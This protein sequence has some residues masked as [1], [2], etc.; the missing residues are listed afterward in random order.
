MGLNLAGL[1]HGGGGGY[2][3]LYCIEYKVQVQY[4]YPVLK[5]VQFHILYLLFVSFLVFHAP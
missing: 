1:I 3:V 2:T 5:M 4:L